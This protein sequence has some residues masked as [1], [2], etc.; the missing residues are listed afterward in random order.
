MGSDESHFNGFIPCEGQSY[1]TVLVTFE[2]K[3]EGIESSL[4][5][6][7]HSQINIPCK[8][9]YYLRPS[10]WMDKLVITTDHL[11]KHKAH[12]EIDIDAVILLPPS[13]FHCLSAFPLP[14]TARLSPSHTLR[15][16]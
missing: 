7:V 8:I 12:N 9:Y 16:N 1:K 11:N 4:L 15:P 5:G 14:L 3:G 13:V 6:G 2:E 10:C